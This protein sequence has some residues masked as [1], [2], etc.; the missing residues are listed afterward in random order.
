M[1]STTQTH[2]A[3]IETVAQILAED[4]VDGSAVTLTE[5]T[6]LTDI[7]LKSLGLARLTITL[8]S[9]TGYD[10]FSEDILIA[11][12]KTVGDL[13]RAYSGAPQLVE[14]SR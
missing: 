7:G 8:E 5:D 1:L 10:P 12:M 6:N 3:V 4:N 2:D 14:A 9:I 11:D 13:V